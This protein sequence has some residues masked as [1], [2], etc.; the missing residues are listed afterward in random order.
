LSQALNGIAA[1]KLVQEIKI[2]AANNRIN[3]KAAAIRI[4]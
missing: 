1:K 3:M 4:S 2:P